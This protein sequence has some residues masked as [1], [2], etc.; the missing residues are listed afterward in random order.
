MG[1]KGEDGIVIA[2]GPFEMDRV[3]IDGRVKSKGDIKDEFE[4]D[5]DVSFPCNQLVELF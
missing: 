4:V 1:E 3:E 2:H 5:R